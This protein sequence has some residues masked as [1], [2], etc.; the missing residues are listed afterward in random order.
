PAARRVEGEDPDR[1]RSAAEEAL[2]ARA[3]LAGGL[4]R[5]GDREDLVRLR[6]ASGDQVR[7]PMREHARLAGARAGD[8][9]ERPLGLEDGL[10]LRGIQVGE[11][12]LGGGRGHPPSLARGLAAA[13]PRG[14]LRPCAGGGACWW[15]W[16]QDSSWVSPPRRQ[17]RETSTRPST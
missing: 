1:P 6:A 5:E 16:R 12:A 15:C 13:A 11:I 2:E 8:D 17:G 10:P 7:H 9:E 3:H 14:K 4:V